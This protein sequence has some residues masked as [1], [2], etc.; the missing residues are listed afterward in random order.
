VPA[1]AQALPF[2]NW[3]LLASLA[4]GAFVFAA[5]TGALTEVTRGYLRFTTFTAALAA[6]L[7][8]L[9]DWGLT[10][11]AEQLAIE[12]ADPTLDTLRRLGL[13]GLA[14]GGFTYAVR[15]D[16]R[17]ERDILALVGAGA[18]ALALG[19]A[20]I[21]WAATL[22]DAVPLLVQLVLLA[23]ASGGSLAALTLGHWY[24]VTP[25]LSVGPLVAQT[26]LLA[27][28]VGLQLAVF[29]VW[30]S[31]GGGPGQ[32]AFEAIGGPQALYGWLRLVVTLVFPL[33]LVVM[34][35]QTARTRSMESATGLLYIAVA[36][37][38]AGTIGAAALYVTGGL[39]V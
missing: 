29:V 33:V 4:A 7:A 1:F 11:P 38:F 35:H 5:L 21:G 14:I 10:A 26:R 31:F 24:L 27:A 18:A 30:A 25:R 23:A 28:L 34:A 39:L 12:A 16:R 9:V 20:A 15:M 17:R 22:P 36:A 32:S 37:I 19:A 13:A 6:G 3:M 8:L 2:V